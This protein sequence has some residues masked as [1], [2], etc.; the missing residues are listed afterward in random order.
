MVVLRF[1]DPYRRLEGVRLRQEVGVPGDQL[2]FSY[3]GHAH[4]WLLQLPRPNVQR[5]E[6]LLELRHPGNHLETITD[7]ANPRRAPGAFGDKSVL[8]FP[9]YCEPSWLHTDTRADG[10]RRELRIWSPALTSDIATWTWSPHEPSKPDRRTTRL[11]LANDGPEYER[12]AGLDRYVAAMIAAD[13][14]PPFHLALLAPGDRNRWYA[15]DPDYAWAL[16]R[17]VLPELHRTLGTAG[18]AI[19]MGASL[20][21]LAM[22]HAQR[23]YPGA[24]AGLFL[25]SGSFFMPK[26]DSHE[27]DFSG[28]RRVTRFVRRVADVGTW[29]HPVRTVL[30]CGTGEE[31]LHNNRAMARTLADQGYPAVLKEVPD[32]HNYVGWRDAFDP[33]LT[34]LLSTVWG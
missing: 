11:L 16:A 21:G 31:N 33:H 15:A 18:P 5:M 8:E 29:P 30:T 26:F 3:D 19:G 22:L 1:H 13:R 4:G 14:V 6:Y 20:G 12:L 24:F 32:A 23:R 34:E 28:Y 9:E 10:S 17:D 25:Q 2:D 7:P 27:S